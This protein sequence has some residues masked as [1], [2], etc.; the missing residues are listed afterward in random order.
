MTN[1]NS[2]SVADVADLL[3]RNSIG[4][5]VI[6]MIASSA[7]VFAFP[8]SII[9][10][11]KMFWWGIIN[12]LMG[13]RLLEVVYWHFQTPA[14]RS[15]NA[16]HWLFRFRTGAILTALCWGLFGAFSMPWLGDV[17]FVTT[18]IIL[19]AL[20]GAAPTPL[21]ADRFLALFYSCALILPISVMGLFDLEYM[22]QVLGGMGVFFALTMV[23][24]GLK[25]TGFTKH[26]IYL[27]NHNQK[28]LQQVSLDK[29]EL[30]LKNDALA[31]SNQEI[32]KAKD[33]LAEEVARQT[34]DLRF[35]SEHDGLT[36][37]FNRAAFLSRLQM[38]LS[39]C[40]ASRAI[41]FIDLNKFKGINDTQGHDTGDEVLKK[42]ASI[43]QELPGDPVC[44][45][46]GGDEFVLF[47]TM[48]TN[49]VALQYADL[50]NMLLKN[51]Q[52]TFGFEVS[53]AIGIAFSNRHGQDADALIRRADIAMFVHKRK[54]YGKAAVVFEPHYLSELEY[55]EYL[56]NGL[57]QAIQN[58]EL[59]LV[60]QPVFNLH[61]GKVSGYEALVRWHFKQQVIEP[62]EFIPLAE[63][64]HLICN[65]GF[66]VLERAIKAMQEHVADESIVLAVNVS[67]LQLK[68]NDFAKNL[69]QIL[70]TTQ[71]PASRLQLEI[72]ESVFCDEPENLMETFSLLSLKGVRFC[73]DDFGT[74]YSSMVQLQA[75]PFST[76]KLDKCFISD[77]EG[78]GGAIIRS[79]VM[80]AGE[81]N[82]N[83][84]VEGVE[85]KRQLDWVHDQ[86][87]NTI[88]GYFCA[89]P[90]S[91]PAA[92]F[93]PALVF[94]QFQSFH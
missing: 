86:G 66:W 79:V 83:V 62:E 14:K 38:A 74:G 34:E 88:Q 44:C 31:K 90:M 12:L 3:Y 43:L 49:D 92:D 4:G 81:L 72:T 75:F 78:A 67:V 7:L 16:E 18:V 17:E 82:M 65:I 22:R 84:V 42:I 69:L 59:F 40:S 15:S 58:D 45:R 27:K 87:I 70:K 48:E 21:S 39:A 20:A 19:S 8:A 46:W 61:S 6:C 54:L 29:Q 71:F 57:A 33:G 5:I 11:Q 25:I 51:Q 73:L 24:N 37:L 2:H 32:I 41:L 56:R 85:N 77:L 76:I 89:K 23:F 63:Q 55:K 52:P 64:S 50:I 68:T 93:K 28:L 10:E 30:A 35:L 91:K 26:A 53:A 80:L 13:L 36:G 94:E 9:F 1:N 60:F 47:L